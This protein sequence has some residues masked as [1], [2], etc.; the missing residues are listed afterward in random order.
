MKM[1]YQLIFYRLSH[2]FYIN[3]LFPKI[4]HAERINFYEVQA[5]GIREVSIKKCEDIKIRVSKLNHQFMAAIVK[6][7]STALYLAI[8]FL[9]S[10]SYY[11]KLTF[12]PLSTHLYFLSSSS[13]Y[14]II[15]F[16]LTP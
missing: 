10:I 13:N 1:K 3:F 7:F 4:S 14:D 9:L 15:S 5:I 2:K 12:Y 6:F 11:S 8:T 16:V